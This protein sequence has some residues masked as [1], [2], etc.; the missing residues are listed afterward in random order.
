MIFPSLVTK[1]RTAKLTALVADCAADLD[2]FD[3]LPYSTALLV[4]RLAFEWGNPVAHRWEFFHRLFV[5]FPNNVDNLV[6][7]ARYAAVYSGENP[8]LRDASAR[9]EEVKRGKLDLKH[10]L[11]AITA[12][13][14]QRESQMSATIKRSLKTVKGKTDKVRGQFRYFWEC[15]I[16]SSMEELEGLSVQLR[17]A[18]AEII[19]EYNQLCLVY[20]NNPYV[21]RT[22]ANFLYQVANDED[23]GDFL[24]FTSRQLRLGKRTRIERCYFFATRQFPQLPREDDHMALAPSDGSAGPARA[25]QG[26]SIVSVGSSMTSS[27]GGGERM[28]TD[29]ERKTQQHYVETMID[30]VRIPSIRYGPALV[31]LLMVVVVPSVLIPLTVMIMGTIQTNANAGEMLGEAAHLRIALGELAIFLFHLAASRAGSGGYAHYPCSLEKR[32]EDT[33][34]GHF[35]WDLPEHWD[36]ETDTLMNMIITTRHHL[37]RTTEKLAMLDADKFGTPYGTAFGPGS[38]ENAYMFVDGSYVKTANSMTDLVTAVLDIAVQVLYTS[39]PQGMR[40]L[41][42]RET[43]WLVLNN[44][45]SAMNS[46][47]GTQAYVQLAILELCRNTTASVQPQVIPAVIIPLLLGLAVNAFVIYRLEKEKAKIFDCFKALPKSALSAIVKQLNPG[48]NREKAPEQ[49]DSEND[50]DD[51][52]TGVSQQELNALRVLSTSVDAHS[53]WLSRGWKFVALLCLFTAAMIVVTILII[54]EAHAIL[55]T[56]DLAIP[57]VTETIGTTLNVHE[58][59]LTALRWG[60]MNESFI[61]N[62]TILKYQTQADPWKAPF[63]ITVV[64]ERLTNCITKIGYF[65]FGNQMA[66]GQGLTVTG[67]EYIDMVTQPTCRPDASEFTNILDTTQCIGYEDVLSIM[68][69]TAREIL[70]PGQVAY[71]TLNA[72]TYEKANESDRNVTAEEIA[73]MIITAT[74]YVHFDDFKLSMI[75]TWITHVAHDLWIEPSITWLVD[76]IDHTGGQGQIVGLLLPVIICCI[77]VIA[78]G[79]LLVPSYISQ[80]WAAKWALR[81]LLFCDPNVVV[82]AP[83]IMKLLSN[84]WTEIEERK[85]QGD[86]AFYETVVSNLLDGVLFL[87]IDLDVLSANNAVE[88]ILHVAPKDAL[89]KNL[90]D[91]LVPVEGKE[92][93]ITT[94]FGTIQAAFRAQRSPSI[95]SQVEIETPEGPVSLKLALTAVSCSGGVQLEPVRVEGLAMLVLVI[96]DLSSAIASNNLLMEEGVK[97]EKL[98]LMILPPLIVQKLQSGEKGICFA[99]K[100]ASIMFVDVVSFTPWCGSHTADYVMRFLNRMFLEFDRIV[101]LYDRLLKIKMIGDCYMNSGGVFDTDDNP[102]AHTK[103]MVSFGIDIINALRLLDIELHETV[104]MRVGVNTGGPIVAG[105]LGIDKPTFDILGPA[106]VTA[107][108][109]E[110]QGVPMNVH[111]PEHSYELIKDDN[112]QFREKGIVE[113]KG[114]SYHTYIVTGYDNKE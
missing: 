54:S 32:W 19:R 57:T 30:S 9:I 74:S 37:D 114:K 103:Q 104:R 38:G 42:E 87:S 82:Q 58:L 28:E 84:D 79:F 71:Q 53:S 85:D 92:G 25:G 66:G 7:F 102:A 107:S 13:V 76:F 94:F 78:C 60:I 75:L 10:L 99:V 97:S 95:E 36:N 67:E 69:Q 65:R 80:A 26:A 29:I 106:I 68:I 98:L 100:S 41:L 24:M 77:V 11:F 108:K 43:I 48:A 110:Q 52:I 88:S 96:K 47:S 86:I 91:L 6:L 22:Y 73:E 44:M 14:H 113:V 70:L 112:F 105:V 49:E 18:Q 8:N 21:A 46:V 15:V 33:W 61:G 72:S 5:R 2:F 45:R 35:G 16:R 12:T 31:I 17:D 4:S 56:L 1:F 89:G 109:M 90:K 59:A 101:K 64:D 23:A 51:F 93:A 40:N 27:V 55:D 3:T 83:P 81:L 111:I 20:P 39:D 50:S 62:E 63:P 34:G